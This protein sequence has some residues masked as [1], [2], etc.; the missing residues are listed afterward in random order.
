MSRSQYEDLERQ[1]LDDEPDNVEATPA[2]KPAKPERLK[3]LPV[4]FGRVPIAWLSD[5]PWPSP[6]DAQGRLL[7]YLLYRSR[8]GQRG[9][10]L[11]NAVAAELGMTP[12]TKQRCLLRLEQAGRVRVER[13]DHGAPVAWAIVLVG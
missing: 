4:A 13:T 7:I 9:V 5:G 6:F 2:N 3:R 1:T 11:T 10:K 12:R 8:W